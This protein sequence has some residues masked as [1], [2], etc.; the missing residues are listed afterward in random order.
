MFVFF[1]LAATC[2]TTF[3]LVGDVD[4]E[5]LLGGV[6][7]GCIACAALLVNNIRDLAQDRTVGKRTLS[8]LIGGTASKVLFG[9]LLL[10]PYAILLFLTFLYPA[11]SLVFLTVLLAGPAVLIAVTGRTPKE[12][13]LALSL[14]GLTGLTYGVGL[15]LA[16]ALP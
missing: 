10:V 16:L 5:S 13:I 2:G 3:V 1:G 15:A 8:V 12:L 14:T 4:S 6:A 7:I 11:A 9:L